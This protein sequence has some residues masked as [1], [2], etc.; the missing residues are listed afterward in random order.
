MRW[1]ASDRDGSGDLT[2]R[3]ERSWVMSAIRISRPKR[4]WSA[5]PA[6]VLPVGLLLRLFRF[7]FN[8]TLVL[9]HHPA[10]KIGNEQ[11][12]VFDVDPGGHR[13][14]VRLLQL[15]RSKEMRMSLE[16]GQ[17]RDFVCGSNGIGWPTL[18]EASPEESAEIRRASR[19]ELPE[20]GDSASPK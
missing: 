14:R 4:D 19:G 13:L 1:I 18:R 9:D 2:L 8:F 7:H 20:P 16:E 6:T 10:G 3:Y 5:A 12:R 15:R 17:E 11:V